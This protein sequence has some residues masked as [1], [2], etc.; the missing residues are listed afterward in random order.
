MP[1]SK[2]LLADDRSS[3]FYDGR[4][5]RNWEVNKNWIKI[6]GKVFDNQEVVVRDGM[7]WFFDRQ[8]KEHT[9]LVLLPDGRG[10]RR[11]ATRRDLL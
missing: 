7:A 2:V 11:P 10:K 8:E 5:I 1:L 3:F 4:P 6:N 9:L